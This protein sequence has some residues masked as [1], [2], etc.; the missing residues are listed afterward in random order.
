MKI[1]IYTAIFLLQIELSALSDIILL[2]ELA[3]YKPSSEA[4]RKR[5][6][7]CSQ[8]LVLHR[9]RSPRVVSAR[10]M[11]IFQVTVSTDYTIGRQTSVACTFA[12]SVNVRC[13][14]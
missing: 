12:Y 2:L 13:N 5:T 1:K 14:E 4:K 9:S 6:V 7:L 11:K 10:S 8:L 3:C